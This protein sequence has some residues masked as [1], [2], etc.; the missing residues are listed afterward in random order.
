MPCS[1]VIAYLFPI[2]S[3]RLLEAVLLVSESLA[4]ST[5]GLN[6][7]YERC[8]YKELIEKQRKTVNRIGGIAH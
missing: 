5:A 3:Y 1:V 8:L 2:L 7:Y 6:H 4:Q